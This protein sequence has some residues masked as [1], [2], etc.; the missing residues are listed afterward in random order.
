MAEDL[1]IGSFY[2]EE[3]QEAY[4]TD[5]TVYKIGRV[6]KKRKY[7][8]VKQ[9]YVKWLYYPRKFNSWVDVSSVEKINPE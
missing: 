2:N 5:D 4:V 9:V 7:R 1:I 6:L 3:L 8:G